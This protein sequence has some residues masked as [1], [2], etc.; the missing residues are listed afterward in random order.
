MLRFSVLRGTSLRNLRHHTRSYE[1]AARYILVALSLRMAVRRGCSCALCVLLRCELPTASAGYLVFCA[2]CLRCALPAAYA[3]C[4]LKQRFRAEFA[5]LGPPR[6]CPRPVTRMLFPGLYT[7]RSSLQ[8]VNLLVCLSPSFYGGNLVNGLPSS[9]PNLIV[10]LSHSIVDGIVHVCASR[11]LDGLYATCAVLRGVYF[12]AL[13][14]LAAL[15]AL[16]RTIRPG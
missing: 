8:S 9:L 16:R 12:H 2:T 5:R 6:L 1:H 4:S 15:C 3:D 10:C 13:R 7:V 11:R 14:D